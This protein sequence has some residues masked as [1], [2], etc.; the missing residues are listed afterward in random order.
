MARKKALRKDPWNDLVARKENRQVGIEE[1]FVNL[2]IGRIQSHK[3]K[4]E[5]M[6]RMHRIARNR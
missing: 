3:L 6:K 2:S 1:V 5:L 4:K